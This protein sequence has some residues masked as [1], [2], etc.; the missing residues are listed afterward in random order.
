MA[1][2]SAH[3]T[4]LEAVNRMLS[5]VGEAPVNSLDSGLGDAAVA[6]QYLR[7]ESRTIQKRGYQVNTL[8]NYTLSKNVSNQFVVPDNT[9]SVDTVGQSARHNV[10]LK[11]S[12]DDTKWLLF[13]KDTNSETW[14]NVS[15]LTVDLVQFIA[16]N[17]LTPAL[18][19]YI[20]FSAGHAF[21]KGA[22]SSQVLWQFTNEDVETAL[23]DVEAEEA[24]NEDANVLRQSP[25]VYAVAFRRNPLF[26]K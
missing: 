5:S 2:L 23:A 3:I 21:Q 8:E 20:L 6:L 26:G 22:M 16:F 18:Q 13:D 17:N 9:L 24:N 25:S 15:T 7:Q 1:S 12:A 11:R 4:E 14:P 10:V 19:N